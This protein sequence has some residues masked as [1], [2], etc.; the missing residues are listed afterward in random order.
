MGVEREVI[1]DRQSPCKDNFISFLVGRQL[2]TAKYSACSDFIL[3]RFKEKVF[4]FDE[5]KK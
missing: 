4:D 5:E 1:I 2:L 3:R